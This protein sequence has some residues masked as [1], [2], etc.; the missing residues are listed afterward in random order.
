M[1]SYLNLPEKT[2][3]VLTDDGWYKTGD[4]FRREDGGSYTFVGRTDDM[5]WRKRPGPGFSL[6]NT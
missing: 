4:V 2:Q 6:R 3:Q 5:N 1:A